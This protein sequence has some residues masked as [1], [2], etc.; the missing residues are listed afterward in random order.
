MNAGA[1]RHAHIAGRRA[2]LTLTQQPQ[3]L[4]NMLK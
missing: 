3:G 1:D 4:G 2:L